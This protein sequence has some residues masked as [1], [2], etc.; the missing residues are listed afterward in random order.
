MNMD[1]K[2]LTPQHIMMAPFHLRPQWVTFIKK[3][4]ICKAE[5]IN[6]LNNHDESIIEI[7]VN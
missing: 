4:W 7:I 5:T 6:L 2:D 3:V 1:E